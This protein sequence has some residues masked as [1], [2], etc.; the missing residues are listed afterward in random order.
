MV[1]FPEPDTQE[2]R[3]RV[4]MKPSGRPH[5]QLNP[6]KINQ[7]LL[8]LLQALSSGLS[9]T[10][11]VVDATDRPGQVRQLDQGSNGNRGGRG[12]A[13]GAVP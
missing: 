8:R 2:E 3:C 4:W 11:V 13:K 6:A 10:E 7:K 5:S 9:L 12:L 1:A